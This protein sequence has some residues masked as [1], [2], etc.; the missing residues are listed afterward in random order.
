MEKSWALEVL[1]L[2]G[3]SIFLLFRKEIRQHPQGVQGGQRIWGKFLQSGD[4][5]KE[6]RTFTGTK[7]ECQLYL[8]VTPLLG[9]MKLCPRVGQVKLHWSRLDTLGQR[10]LWSSSFVPNRVAKGMVPALPKERRAMC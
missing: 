7:G 3:V 10:Y 4:I 6:I 1:D 9:R 2:C 5:W 8:P